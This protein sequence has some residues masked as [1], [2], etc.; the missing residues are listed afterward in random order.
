MKKTAINL[1]FLFVSIIQF[2]NAFS[3]SIEKS[4]TISIDETWSAD[5]ISVIADIVVSNGVTLTIDPGVVVQF[6]DHYKMNIQGTILAIGTASNKIKFTAKD[7]VSTGSSGGWYGIRFEETPQTN[8]SSKIEFC[9]F[10]YGNAFGNN[11][12]DWSGGA[13]ALIKVQ[14]VKI[15]NCRFENN[16]QYSTFSEGASIFC[17]Y[18]KAIV[19]N[20]EFINNY[21]DFGGSAIS[22]IRDSSL[23]A[24]NL[25]SGN[26][27]RIGGPVIKFNSSRCY[28][29]NNLIVNNDRADYTYGM[30]YFENNSYDTIVNNTIT[31]NLGYGISM[32][33]SSP[34]IINCI[35][36]NNIQG[37][38]VQDANSHPII[39]YSN[40][41][42][43][44]LEENGNFYRDPLFLGEGEHPYSLQG[45]SSCLNTGNPSWT[46]DSLRL[47]T[48]FAGNERIYIGAESF[49]DIGAYELQSNPEPYLTITDDITDVFLMPD[50][51]YTHIL[52]IYSYP[53]TYTI[54]F[55]NSP[56]GLTM[57]DDTISWVANSTQEKTTF[58]TGFVINNGVLTDTI[59]GKF[60]VLGDNEFAQ[61]PDEDIVWSADTIRV[62][63]DLNIKTGRT[64][65]ILP[66]VYVEF[67]DNYGIDVDGRI[68]AE[69]LLNEK[70]TFTAKDTVL[71]DSTGGW[72]AL[73][74]SKTATENDSSKISNCVFSYGNA[75]RD[76]NF[77]EIRS[78]GALAFYKVNNA[79]VENCFFYKNMAAQYSARGGAIYCNRSKVL[80]IN[81]IFKENY[82]YRGG[83]LACNSDFSIIV[84]NI[85]RN[86]FS[87]TVGSAM[88]FELSR[89]LIT[90]N[91]A[92][93]NDHFAIYTS[94]S[95]DTLINNTF[96][97]NTPADLYTYEGSIIAKNCYFGVYFSDNTSNSFS[98][99]NVGN[100]IVDG[101]GNISSEPNFTKS[102]TYYYSLEGYSPC[103]NAG[104]PDF[105]TNP[106][107]SGL[108]L[109]G[110]FRIDKFTNGKRIDIGAYEYN[111]SA[112]ACGPQEIIIAENINNGVLIDTIEV[113]YYNN[114]SL[115]YSFLSGNSGNIL[116]LDNSTGEIYVAD[117]SKID[118]ELKDSLFFEVLVSDGILS[119][120]FNYRLL[121]KNVNEPCYINGWSFEVME[122]ALA[123]TPVGLIDASDVDNDQLSFS[124]L[125]GNTSDAF[126][127]NSETGQ[128]S[129]NNT[130]ILNFETIP[131][132]NLN[133]RVSDDE[134]SDTATIT[135]HLSDV[136]ETGISPFQG[137]ARSGAVNFVIDSTVYIGLG[138]SIDSAYSDFWCYNIK[139]DCW[140]E[141]ERF[142]GAARS[143]ATAFV[144]N[145]KAYV[146]LGRST[147]P[148]I[149]YSDFY[150]YSP[151]S[152]TWKQVADF[153]G[154]ARYDAVNFVIDSFAYVGTGGNEVDELKDFW[155][156]NASTDEWSEIA[157]FLG[158]KRRGAVG[159]EIDG[160][161]YV[162]GGLYFDTYTVQLSDIQEY[163]PVTNSWTEKIYAD[164][165][166]LSFF[167]ASTVEG[168]NEAFICYGNKD[169]IVRYVP[170]T[171]LVES[172][173]D[174]LNLNENR[175]NA[176]SFILG[177]TVY[178]G[179][180]YYSQGFDTYYQ[181]DI[182]ALKL[183]F[184][185]TGVNLSNNSLDEN[186]NKKVVA[187]I[188]SA[189]GFNKSD[190]YTYSL[191]SG[192]GE[193]D[194]GS[195][196][197]SQDTLWAVNLD[198]ETKQ[199]YSIRVRGTNQRR[200]FTEESFTLTL[201]DVNEAP[202]D[203][204]LSNN[205]ITENNELG[206]KIG[207]LSAQDEDSNE[208]FV[209]ELDN[210]FE[211]N[212]NDLF[213]II[214][215]NLIAN[216]VFDFDKQNIC[217]LGIR[218]SDKGGL[219]V[220]QYFY[221]Y[222]NED[223][224]ISIVEPVREYFS[225][226]P[227]PVS[228]AL[229]IN[230]TSNLGNVNRIKI[231]DILGNLI[232][233]KHSISSSE[234]SIDVS[235]V[236]PGTYFLV[237]EANNKTL[238][239]KIIIE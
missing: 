16:K 97:D 159:F 235:N 11:T 83:A 134:F 209:Y 35:I 20:C 33:S 208:T 55:L 17:Y 82:S 228:N 3:I 30:L 50:S 80:V 31:D 141:I 43:A 32:K 89:T 128:I 161:G 58:E 2:T 100:T 118:F 103:V 227:N 236:A 167:S 60:R 178:F 48:D 106:I 71:T 10:E 189:E 52:E 168:K 12:V 102:S 145:G 113:H 223:S 151:D 44:G 175:W 7:T 148:T 171:N 26:D 64:L 88:H 199:E 239:E 180:G 157:E 202:T 6:Q 61:L 27:S 1:I 56:D 205:A 179:L 174:L 153:G 183:P 96:V 85:F 165:I 38:L 9:H 21:S 66:D 135:I 111:G 198:F 203:I 226:Y 101:I 136:V 126:L 169:Q 69:G 216:T 173:G 76:S 155:K 109:S 81:N 201:N 121:I 213:S 84:K 67:Q 45:T 75:I 53:K 207:V 59:W 99:C 215:S 13:I 139:T 164:G 170:E 131:T 90:N 29:A 130:E 105:T 233:T 147:N 47:K 41:E 154:S 137:F 42:G 152:N 144:I 23:I 231:Y 190:T 212:N 46:I 78:G 34:V 51:S 68:L 15:S 123:G 230:A 92:Y 204:F 115:S 91:L 110:G 4:G 40:I 163:N 191:I 156:Y 160:K 220:N 162:S 238:I 237:L 140:T 149:Y 95:Y 119:D 24:N 234:Y 125:S 196:I 138:E 232:I 217:L 177:D 181:K 197:I 206:I 114:N 116:T 214:D 124:I 150:E 132:F 79:I 39:S 57:N 158:D 5:T 19:T 49:I 188:L 187:G 98:Y 211:D 122:N 107:L 184:I 133:V 120:T 221:I 87:K 8:D 94:Y 142:P 192:E 185:P 129:V 193:S 127:I 194:N 22:C 18:S 112:L 72:N 93:N 108:D 14:K 182:L 104:S 218:T 176:V 25:F 65:T 37:N 210:S 229:R 117:S 86:N 166:N 36:T 222:V 70:I 172:L 77:E 63:S 186:Q 200:D 225:I 62:Y 224:N 74:F 73:R 219:S 195:F 143:S 28:F 146:G 54:N